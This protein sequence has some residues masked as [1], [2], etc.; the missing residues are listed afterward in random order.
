MKDSKQSI[1]SSDLRTTVDDVERRHRKEWAQDNGGEEPRD[2]GLSR[3]SSRHM[4]R[5]CKQ[6]R[7]GNRRHPSVKGRVGIKKRENLAS[8]IMKIKRDLPGNRR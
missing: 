4:V 3:L 1:V 6:S 2:R 8:I 7:F 5:K